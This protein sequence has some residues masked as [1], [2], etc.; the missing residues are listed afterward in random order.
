MNVNFH[1]A[2]KQIELNFVGFIFLIIKLILFFFNIFIDLFI[3]FGFNN[4]MNWVLLWMDEKK[5]HN[6]TVA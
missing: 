4:N 3:Y 2:K 5:L 6:N 1:G